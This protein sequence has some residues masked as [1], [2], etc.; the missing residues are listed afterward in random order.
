MLKLTRHTAIYKITWFY[1]N[2][3][4]EKYSYV[5]I[6][7]K[8]CKEAAKI[9]H[10][11]TF[12]QTL[13]QLRSKCSFVSSYSSLGFSAAQQTWF[14]APFGE[15]STFKMLEWGFFE[16]W[17][18]VPRFYCLYLKK[19]LIETVTRFV[20]FLAFITFVLIVYFY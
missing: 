11:E 15:L 8:M 13:V 18:Q 9:I 10:N 19:I 2:C 14:S 16:P 7:C 4:V 1:F 12:K 5:S 6:L 3:A 20:L 17:K